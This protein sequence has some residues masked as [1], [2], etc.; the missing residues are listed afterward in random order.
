MPWNERS[1]MDERL[2]AISD[3]PIE[4]VRKALHERARALRG[5]HVNPKTRQL[6]EPVPG[7]AIG[8]VLVLG[9]EAIERKKGAPDEPVVIT[10][11]EF[12]A[13]AILQTGAFTRVMSMPNGAPG[14][15]MERRNKP[16]AFMAE[17]SDCGM[18]RPASIAS[19]AARICGPSAR[20][21]SRAGS[22]PSARAIRLSVNGCPAARWPP[23]SAGGTRGP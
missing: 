1:V 22:R 9:I 3:E 13:L 20:A 15:G 19:R 5:R 7:D 11:G 4:I 23:H 12:D 21:A 16:A 17:T 14:R 6:I 2:R 8:G 10:E 18:R